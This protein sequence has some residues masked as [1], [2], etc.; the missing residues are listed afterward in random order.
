[1]PKSKRYYALL[2]QKDYLEDM[3]QHIED[4]ETSSTQTKK[5]V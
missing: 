3:E 5:V 2:E 1:M 4:R